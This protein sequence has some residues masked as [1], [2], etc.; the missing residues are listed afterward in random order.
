MHVLHCFQSYTYTNKLGQY[1]SCKFI[2]FPH[3]CEIMPFSESHLVGL[4]KYIIIAQTNISC[5]LENKGKMKKQIR[6]FKFQDM[7]IRKNI[8]ILRL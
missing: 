7:I 3:L 1:E 4:I 6:K 2:N 8:R 5:Y